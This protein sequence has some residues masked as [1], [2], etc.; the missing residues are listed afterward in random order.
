[1]PCVEV[2]AGYRRRVDCNLLYLFQQACSHSTFQ[3]TPRHP[4]DRS[5]LLGLCRG[6]KFF[7]QTSG[8]VEGALDQLALPSFATQTLPHT[9][10][11][12]PPSS[13]KRVKKQK[14]VHSN[15]L[16][17]RSTRLRRDQTTTMTPSS[18]SHTN[19]IMVSDGESE[20]EQ[21]RL[22]PG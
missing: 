10:I 11:D 3:V 2:C 14:P 6:D 20:R 15:S 17:R 18:N 4:G 22:A 21:R 19:P 7:P 13:R 16:L 5:P 9:E 12:M 8:L 1:M